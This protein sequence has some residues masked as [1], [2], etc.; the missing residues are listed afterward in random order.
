MS[1]ITSQFARNSGNRSIRAAY[2]SKAIRIAVDGG[3]W[4]IEHDPMTPIPHDLYHDIRQAMARQ[5]PELRYLYDLEPQDALTDIF[6]AI[7]AAGVEYEH[8]CSD[9]YIPVMPET[10]KLISQYKYKQNVTTFK[11]NITGKPWY[12]VPFAYYN[13]TPG[14]SDY[15]RH[16]PC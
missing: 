10:K 1:Y 6:S 5:Y 15:E 2:R 3:K 16:A 13:D 11:D 9:L 14:I 8:W 4:R 7:Q 12:E